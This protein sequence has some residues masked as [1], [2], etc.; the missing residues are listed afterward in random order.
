[1]DSLSDAHFRPGTIR[2]AG[3]YNPLYGSDFLFVTG[4]PMAKRPFYTHPDPL[5]PGSSNGFDLLFR[6]QEL[7]TGGQRHPMRRAKSGWWEADG[8]P[9]D[10]GTRYG[11]SLDGEEVRPD[12]RSPSQ[13]DGVLGL[14][15]AVEHEAY[16]WRDSSW[17]GR[18]LA[19]VKVRL[20]SMPIVR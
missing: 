3:V 19:S 15:E 12:P 17:R 7:V 5:R 1:M 4:Y 6:G 10:A 8:V 11:F 14:S 13:P 20:A 16:E 18:P 2:H 9:A